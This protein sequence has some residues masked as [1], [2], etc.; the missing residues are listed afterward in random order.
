MTG[1]VYQGITIEKV[2]M[3]LEWPFVDIFEFLEKDNEPT[4]PEG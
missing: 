3:Y 4:E 2:V 1:R